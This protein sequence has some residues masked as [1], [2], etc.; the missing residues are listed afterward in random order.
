[1]D[2]T[3]N[4]TAEQK[5][6][7]EKTLKEL[8]VLYEKLNL[9]AKPMPIEK[10]QAVRIPGNIAEEGAVPL[11]WDVQLLLG[12][13]KDLTLAPDDNEF[14]LLN[15]ASKG[16]VCTADVLIELIS[17]LSGE[18]PNSRRARKIFLEQAG[19]LP[20]LIDLPQLG[21]DELPM[22]WP[23]LSRDQ[24]SVV[25]HFNTDDNAE[26]YVRSTSLFSYVL[27]YLASSA[28]SPNP[29]EDTRTDQSRLWNEKKDMIILDR[30]ESK[31]EL[32]ND[33]VSNMT[34]MMFHKKNPV[35]GID[36]DYQDEDQYDDESYDDDENYYS[37][38]DEFDDEDD[39]YG[40][41]DDYDDDEYSDDDDE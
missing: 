35:Y 38:D 16:I 3:E 28:D 34:E 29:V 24:C 1:M 4:L 15:D 14:P 40:D 2:T 5:K 41:N 31:L 10:I 13:D 17:D 26:F 7:W 8:T 20:P 36:E 19:D 11:P 22:L 12:F 21:G 39:D 25:L 32:L 6:F 30:I 18:E 37:E 33:A 9:T 27:Q 23:V